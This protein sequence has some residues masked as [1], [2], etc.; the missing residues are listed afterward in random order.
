MDY[1]PLVGTTG[2]S[3]SSYFAVYLIRRWTDSITFCGGVKNDARTNKS[4]FGSD[5]IHINLNF[6]TIGT[7]HTYFSEIFSEPLRCW[8]RIHVSHL[9]FLRDSHRT[10]EK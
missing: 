5:L 4:H 1:F 8:C 7:F 6:H 9:L 3:I 10:S 2:Y